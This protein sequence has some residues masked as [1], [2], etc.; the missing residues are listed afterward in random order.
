MSTLIPAV[1]PSGAVT[2][3]TACTGNSAGPRRSVTPPVS[4]TVLTPRVVGTAVARYNFAARDMREL[5]LRE[6][7][8]V[9]IYSRMGG[10]RGWWRGETNGRVSGRTL[11]PCSA[12]RDRPGDAGCHRGAAPPPAAPG[13]P[14]HRPELPGSGL[15]RAWP[16]PCVRQVLF[17]PHEGTGSAYSLLHAPK[18]GRPQDREQGPGVLA[19]P[20]LPHSKA[21]LTPR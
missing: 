4:P 1:A 7:D 17:W 20:L 14:G 19:G 2:A 3:L 18:A 11:P 8:V 12:G 15:I 10:D 5:S 6:G 9:K 21:P 13:T 16:T